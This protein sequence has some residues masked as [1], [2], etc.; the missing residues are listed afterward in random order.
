MARTPSVLERLLRPAEGDLPVEYAHRLLGLEFT[1]AETA[2]YLVLSE[3]AQL[4]TLSNDEQN[5]L[6]E[7]LIA[8]DVLMIL[9]AKA[10]SSLKPSS[11]A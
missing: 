5:E 3:K 2:R 1:E 10:K 7:L 8:N 9:R 6:D 11:A 4:G